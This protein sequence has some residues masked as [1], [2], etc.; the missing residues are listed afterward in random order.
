MADTHQRSR[1][2]T[3]GGAPLVA[4]LAAAL[5]L[6]GCGA[7]AAQA[8]T[9]P[10]PPPTPTYRL[11]GKFAT[12]TAQAWTPT[13]PPDAAQHAP[14]PGAQAQW[15]E[16]NLPSG[17]GFAFHESWLGV[18]A[19]HGNIA[20]SCSQSGSGG[21]V[22]TVKTTNAGASWPRVADVNQQ[23]DGCMNISVDALD[24]QIAVLNGM[25][26]AVTR[27]GGQSWRTSAN[28]PLTAVSALATVGSRTYALYKG[29]SSDTLGV[30]VDGLVSWQDITGPMRGQSIIAFWA[31]PTTGALLAETATDFPIVP[32]L[33]R[34]SDGGAHWSSQ[35]LPFTSDHA[36]VAQAA[37]SG[38]PW[39]LCADIAGG[40]QGSIACST[41]SGAHWRALPAL[42]DTGLRGY[43]VFGVADD[44]ATLAL[45]TTD[46]E[47]R[48]YRL[49]PGA[50]R[51][52]ALGK[53]PPTSGTLLYAPVTGGAGELW[54]FPSIKGGGSGDAN[55]SNVYVA[56]YP[57]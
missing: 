36:M 50:A 26:A 41:D 13:P 49:A 55:P 34:S 2:W 9:A 17:F 19:E 24:P 44:G 52:Q 51:W 31:N 56:P 45:G 27:D 43:G 21:P 46:T 15:S 6:A 32:T 37:T 39:T 35:A 25:G 23:W 47:W 20:Y 29:A 10:T 53:A 57:Y 18:S 33:W 16:V 28:S 3:P 5:T 1:R 48:I 4:A 38:A 11:G 7:A 8:T 12:A 14:I 22:E 54:S 40:M 30:S 42:D